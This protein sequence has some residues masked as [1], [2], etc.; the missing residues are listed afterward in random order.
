M[1]QWEKWT[2]CSASCEGG[3]RIRKRV[4]DEPLHGGKPCIGDTEQTEECN[5]H[6]C[7]REF[8]VCVCLFVGTYKYWACSGPIFAVSIACS[9]C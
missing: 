4:C 5:T 3:V 6:E 9:L 8:Y 1:G 2:D 7:P